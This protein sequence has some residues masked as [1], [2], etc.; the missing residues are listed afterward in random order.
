MWL[1]GLTACS[2]MIKQKDDWYRQPIFHDNT[3]NLKSRLVK[4]KKTENLSGVT[5]A[6]LS[7]PMGVTPNVLS[8]FKVTLRTLG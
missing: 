3:N 8:R 2:N 4:L 5:L 7:Y 1:K 6:W